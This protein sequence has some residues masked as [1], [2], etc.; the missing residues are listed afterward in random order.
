VYRITYRAIEP[1]RS[2]AVGVRLCTV[3]ALLAHG[4]FAQ[5]RI[6][7]WTPNSGLPIGS[8]NLQTRDGYL[9][10]ATFAGLVRYDGS[11]SRFR[12]LPAM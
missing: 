11:P 12:T 3:L 10:M 5:Y 1:Q 2:S 7:S 9:W 6:E 8:V 4:A